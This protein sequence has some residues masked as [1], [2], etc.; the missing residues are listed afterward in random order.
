MD[1]WKFNI[2]VKK[3]KTNVFTDISV[4]HQ[5]VFQWMCGSSDMWSNFVFHKS[6]DNPV[7]GIL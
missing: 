1:S 7:M 6:W 5:S 2:L 3:K 4:C